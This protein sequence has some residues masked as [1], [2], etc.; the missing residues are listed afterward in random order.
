MGSV[1]IHEL[2]HVA[3][4]VLFGGSWAAL[5][6]DQTGARVV[7]LPSQPTGWSRI[8]RSLAGPLAQLL[9]CLAMMATV[10]AE[11]EPLAFLMRGQQYAIWWVAGFIGAVIA[12]TNLLP[13]QGLDGGK[14]VD[15]VRDLIQGTS[16]LAN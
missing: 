6:F 12:L 2:A 13:I 10:A 3:A 14:A 8:I 9:L 5:V 16:G 11:S 15:G 7:I 1:L 4:G